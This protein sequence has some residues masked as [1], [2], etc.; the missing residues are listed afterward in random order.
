MS[1]RLRKKK[2]KKK[3]IRIHNPDQFK[4]GDKVQIICSA[5]TSEGEWCNSWTNDM[6]KAIGSTF[7][8]VESGAI[9]GYQLR[10]PALGGYSYFSFPSFVLR[11][12]T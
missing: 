7:T 4:E 8:I 3:S 1:K 2:N 10:I 11:K 6:T 9:H 5:I 12:I